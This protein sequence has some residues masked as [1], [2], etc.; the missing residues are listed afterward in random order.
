[1]IP[2]L[3]EEQNCSAV[4]LMDGTGAM[5]RSPEDLEGEDQSGLELA[6]C[7]SKEGFFLPF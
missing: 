7:S 6:G 1:M 4:E 2:S 3:Q 5:L